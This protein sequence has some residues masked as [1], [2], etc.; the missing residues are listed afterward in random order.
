MKIAPKIKPKDGWAGLVEN[1][2]HDLPAGLIVSLVALPLCLG[3][4]MASGFPPLA[5][6]VAAVVGGVLVGL[7]SGSH[8]TINGPAAGLIVV[9]LN[10]VESL[11]GGDVAAGYA[12]ALAAVVVAGALIVVFG[13]LGA[14]RLGDFFPSAAIEGM[15]AAIGLIILSKQLHIA[16][17]V[18]PEAKT[19]FA[20]LAEIPGAVRK[21][22]SDGQTAKAALVG[23]TGLLLLVLLPRVKNRYVRKIPAPLALIVWA[24]VLA[25][26]LRLPDRFLT[27]NVRLGHYTAPDFSMLD[28]F[29]FWKA[30][31]TIALV[32]GLETLLSAS[33]VDKLDPYRRRADLGR[34]L[35]AV[36]AGSVVSGFLG[37]LPMI[38]EI[39][40]SSANINSG[41]RT[42]WANVFH[43]CFLFSFVVV[44]PNLIRQI[45]LPALAAILV[46]TGYR[47]ASPK[48]FVRAYKTG[49]EQL[50]VLTTTVVAT[51]LTDLL[52]GVVVG[53]IV[54]IVVHLYNGAP[55]RS[56]FR[57]RLKIE[58]LSLNVY[59]FV[60]YD[61][62]NFTNFIG[63]RRR[64]EGVPAD[65]TVVL[66]F[67]HVVHID[68]TVM[69][70]LQEIVEIRR[71]AG[72]AVEYFGLERLY[73]VSEHPY[74]MRKTTLEP[75]AQ[76]VGRLS[77]RQR[78]LARF[79]YENELSFHPKLVAAFAVLREFVFHRY[80]PVGFQRNVLVK[81]FP[82]Y[83][84]F[85]ADVSVADGGAL[86]YEEITVA[87]IVFR[88][89]DLPRFTLEDETF[90]DKIFEI[91]GYDD[92]DFPEH[93]EFSSRFLL[94]GKD[95]R[96]VRAF[97]SEPMLEW[98]VGYRGY[99]VEAL[100]RTVL[101]HRRFSF[102]SPQ[103][104]AEM[105]RFAEAFALIAAF[106]CEQPASA[107]ENAAC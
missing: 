86:D 76:T 82:E 50:L 47:L 46:F 103:G 12:P 15:M 94:R 3:I 107:D 4:A 48:H 49:L 25:A 90:F 96:A 56:L 106:S 72:G 54:K 24:L 58:N 57:A 65:A 89:V 85:V 43:G 61:S 17:G 63:V 67:S 68:H 11:G 35:T 59:K 23:V 22:F 9:V 71:E 104:A 10:A 38:A 26:A 93:P 91:A 31:V 97:F 87:L 14:G 92:I 74:A 88:D 95:A 53:I 105:Y 52:A 45:P 13:L 29:V 32:Q 98:F 42:R 100:D 44:F 40:R 27:P 101:I 77:A 8:V 33:A 78:S 73:P 6:I 37:G 66:D 30:A 81:N 39:V 1:W 83:S 80:C 7:S 28:T 64:F 20:L 84:I 55:L 41:A 16:L 2:R 34:D 60:F 79:A 102:L 75:K 99:C 69:E 5:G 62:V 51:L 18:T 21:V 70:R 36:G 19:P